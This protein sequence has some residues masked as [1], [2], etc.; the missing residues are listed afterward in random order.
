MINSI[1]GSRAKQVSMN[2]DQC[3]IDYLSEHGPTPRRIAAPEI[4]RLYLERHTT[5]GSVTIEQVQYAMA[6]HLFEMVRAGKIT[7]GAR[8]Q[9]L[10]SLTTEK[11]SFHELD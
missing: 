2:R 6:E 11:G 5:G 1:I 4:C 8:P 9:I 10:L 7:R 3:V